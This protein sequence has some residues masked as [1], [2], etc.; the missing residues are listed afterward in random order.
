MN[1]IELLETLLRGPGGGAQP[2]ARRTDPR[3]A[4]PSETASAGIPQILRDILQGGAPA[5]AEPGPE[6]RPVPESPILSTSRPPSDSGP[7][8]AEEK[9]E[10]KK[11][12]DVKE[13][14]WSVPLGLEQK[15]YVISLSV[16]TLDQ[17]DESTYLKNLAHGLR[18][19]P[20]LC[21]EIHRQFGAPLIT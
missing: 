3:T 21:A 5:P 7:I 14:A 2:P 15:V 20:D 1:A 17:R 19:P 8:S 16:I 13:F 4:E 6:R 18:L 10:F 9:A 12:L 11:P